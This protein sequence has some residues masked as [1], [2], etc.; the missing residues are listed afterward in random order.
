MIEHFESFLKDC[1]DQGHTQVKLVPRIDDNGK[2]AFYAVG[3]CGP[4]SGE[5]FDASVGGNVISG[6]E[7]V[8]EP[9]PVLDEAAD[10]GASAS[11]SPSR[12]CWIPAPEPASEV[13]RDGVEPKILAVA[14]LSD[15]EIA[16]LAEIGAGG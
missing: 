15:A 2:V 5:T 7:E 16:A 1:M 6:D 11:W 14:E 3:Q 4:N 12:T 9:M 10:M 8:A 13:F